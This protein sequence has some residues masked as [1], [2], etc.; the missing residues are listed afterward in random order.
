M[1]KKEKWFLFFIIF[2]AIVS[3]W[4]LLDQLFYMD[5]IIVLEIAKNSYFFA[6]ATI[7]AHP[8]LLQA[9]LTIPSMLFGIK[10]WTFHL[11]AFIFTIATIP[12]L[13]LYAKSK[14]DQKT[15]I[16]AI[17][18]LTFSGW[19]VYAS[20]TN[21][22][23]E[24]ILA[25][26]IILIAYM[27]E[28]NEKCEWW[29]S[30]STGAIIG[31]A[32]LIKET[33]ILIIPV[34]VLLFIF[35]KEEIKEPIK[36]LSA[37][38]IGIGI[39]WIVYVGIAIAT[40]NKGHLAAL[41]G[42]ATRPGYIEPTLMHYLFSYTKIAFWISP[43]FSI[44]PLLWFF[45]KEEKEK[46]KDFSVLLILIYGS[47]FIFYMS[48]V[49]D[50]ARYLLVLAPFLAMLSG[51]FFVKEEINRK[52]A[53]TLFFL[54]II[55]F[56][57]FFF[58][59]TE[60]SMISLERQDLI[61]SQIESRSFNID[62]GIVSETGNPGLVINLRIILLV[63]LI[64]GIS[65]T[66]YFI[67]ERMNVQKTLKKQMLLKEIFFIMLLSSTLGYNVFLA[68]EV[69]F[70]GT[71]P[72]YE[73]TAREIHE[74]AK[75]NDLSEPIILIKDPSMK[76]YL[77]EKYTRFETFDTINLNDEKIKALKA[78]I[79]EG[80]SILLIDI[81]FIN[82]EGELWKVINEECV[83]IYIVENKGIKVGGVWSC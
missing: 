27:I 77:Q 31:I 9:L 79:S 80:G 35:K 24:G 37:I 21:V 41:I 29:V 14:Y 68:E 11:A 82:K 3:R 61:Q 83:A 76:W 53:V 45:K 18:F 39:V 2:S 74:Y 54:T 7:S 40:E 33:A 15:A 51:N 72:N 30:L 8:A 64:A 59:N 66:G 38:L 4:T 70:H 20:A 62:L 60:R 46:R 50:K 5:D 34:V 63:Y 10:E 48:P 13:Y 57:L 58:I 56:G 12:L 75:T 6:P 17:I 55:F 36:K 65:A 43:L 52:K 22:G 78:T 73:K 44:V 49:F 71:S 1:E 67:F 69:L 16:W 25:F 26:F 42:L 47:F 81:P 23:G 28:K 32:T 19:H